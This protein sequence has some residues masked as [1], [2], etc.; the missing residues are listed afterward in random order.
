M[1]QL[2]VEEIKNEIERIWLTKPEDGDWYVQV[3]SKI[4]VS[5]EY[6]GNGEVVTYHITMSSM[7]E[8]PMLNLYYMV[9]LSKVFGT[10][11][12]NDDDR[13]SWMGCETC[14]YGSSYGFTLSIREEK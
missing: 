5:M 4:N 9:E 7:Y 1:K 10:M 2:T 13:F 8:A 14:D 6:G 11:N 3:P 12:I